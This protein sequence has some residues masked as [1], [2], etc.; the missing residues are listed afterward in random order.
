MSEIMEL[1]QTR[2][3]V[4]TMS[5]EWDIHPSPYAPL[6]KTQLFDIAEQVESVLEKVL[7]L[8]SSDG[9]GIDVAYIRNPKP[10]EIS[11]DEYIS[12]VHR[13]IKKL[14]S[15]KLHL[16]A[17]RKLRY[18]SFSLKDYHLALFLTPNP[19]PYSQW[20][21][22]IIKLGFDHYRIAQ[23]V[24]ALRL[25]LI[26]LKNAAQYFTLSPISYNS[27]LYFS[28]S[29]QND[30]PNKNNEYYIDALK[31]SI[32][33]S[34]YNDLTFEL[35]AVCFRA[36]PEASGINTELG[37][38]L[39]NDNKNIDLI[40]TV[41]AKQFGNLSYMRFANRPYS[42]CQNH[43]ENLMQKLITEIL[44]SAN[45]AF[46]P[47][48]FQASHRQL[49]FLETPHTTLH[50]PLIII[51]NLKKHEDEK[52]HQNYL[53]YLQQE[54]NA[55]SVVDAQ[56]ISHISKDKNYLV[57]NSSQ[58]K[59]GSSITLEIIDDDGE[60]RNNSFNTTWQALDLAKQG[61]YEQLDY[62]SK[63]K[64]DFIL[65][66][67]EN[68]KR[69][70][71]G[72]NV[73][74]IL[75]SQKDPETGITRKILKKIEPSKLA[76]L[77]SELWLKEAIRGVGKISGLQ[78]AD[79][80]FTLVATRCPWEK[81]RRQK[82]F[83]AAVTPIEIKNGTLTIQMPKLYEREQELRHAVSG[84]TQACVEQVRDNDFFLIDHQRNV[85]LWRYNTSRVPCLIGAA[86]RCSLQ[87]AEFNNGVLNKR[88]AADETFLPY[89]LTPK[90]K[91]HRPNQYQQLFIEDNGYSANLFCTRSNQPNQ[92]MDKAVLVYNLM[93]KDFEGSAI[94]VMAEPATELLLRTFTYDLIRHHEVSQSSLLEKIAR[95]MLHN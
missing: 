40:E 89:Y 82:A 21:T 9:W 31:F 84:M 2:N 52:I 69:V 88:G 37:R 35:K 17:P 70:I 64:V 11:H 32:F 43:A 81:R 38:L 42:G 10:L 86:D 7:K 39:I 14:L 79:G 74:S 26:L 49:E 91:G 76:M 15:E 95:M 93:A 8:P 68:Y 18:H 13:D 51:D 1:N 63:L 80:Y 73:D 24:I 6:A 67:N 54:L 41:N 55:E 29:L 75:R 4:I 78:V 46:T 77:R 44:N 57:L 90:P 27:D 59:N 30:K 12:E 50:R 33:Y 34:K 66:F 36:Q 62:Y 45:I 83:Y 25:K 16:D 60:V 61:K 20:A 47:R 58:Q 87:A 53:H 28:A 48:I 22:E 3:A 19:R 94:K 23:E 72:C 65:D 71:Q 56:D 92:N 5:S 85:V